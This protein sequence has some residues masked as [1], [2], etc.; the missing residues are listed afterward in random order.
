MAGAAALR[1]VSPRGANVLATIRPTVIG[2]HAKTVGLGEGLGR[3]LGQNALAVDKDDARLES[4]IVFELRIGGLI[5][6]LYQG[7][8]LDRNQSSPNRDD[9]WHGIPPAMKRIPLRLVLLCHKLRRIFCGG[10]RAQHGHR[11]S[12]RAIATTIARW[13][14][15]IELG[16]WRCGRSG[17]AAGSVTSGNGRFREAFGATRC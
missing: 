1:R 17:G 16:T 8:L 6:R 14:V 7:N 11:G 4:L 12:L 15:A 2:Q 9:V 13:T 3:V 5:E 10:L